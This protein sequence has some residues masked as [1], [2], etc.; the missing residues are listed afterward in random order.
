MGA[1]LIDKQNADTICKCV[2]MQIQFANACNV[3]SNKMRAKMWPSL[4]HPMNVLAHRVC[5]KKPSLVIK[6]SLQVMSRGQYRLATRRKKLFGLSLFVLTVS[7]YNWSILIFSLSLREWWGAV[8]VNYQDFPIFSS[9]HQFIKENH[10]F[11]KFIKFHKIFFFGPRPSIQKITNANTNTDKDRKD[12]SHIFHRELI[13]ILHLADN[14][15]TPCWQLHK[16]NNLTFLTFFQGQRFSYSVG[17][18]RCSDQN[19]F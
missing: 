17:F 9:I 2:Q 13:Q 15:L 7:L 14:W 5:A 18:S 19:T 3:H 8:I 12:D 4:F 11:I 10:Q 6:Q 1:K 16:C